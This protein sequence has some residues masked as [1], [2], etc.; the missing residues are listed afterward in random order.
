[1]RR[2][3]WA[4][5]AATMVETEL[6]AAPVAG[7]STILAGARTSAASGTVSMRYPVSQIRPSFVPPAAAT[8]RAPPVIMPVLPSLR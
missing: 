3:V 7:D 1:M 2:N 6:K 5:N 4:F 8:W